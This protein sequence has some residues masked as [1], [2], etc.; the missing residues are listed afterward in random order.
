MARF[1]IAKTEGNW[2]YSI[3]WL[4][5]SKRDLDEVWKVSTFEAIELR[6]LLLR[7]FPVATEPGKSARCWCHAEATAYLYGHG[8]RC[9]EHARLDLPAPQPSE[10]GEQQPAGPFDFDPAAHAR[11]ERIATAVLGG[12]AVET[13]RDEG[14]DIQQGRIIATHAVRWADALI[15]ALDKEA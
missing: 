1:S 7:E 4:D 9:A 13:G 3:I 10:P 11:R 2:P 14:W 12:L 8:P 5:P 6:D 15:A